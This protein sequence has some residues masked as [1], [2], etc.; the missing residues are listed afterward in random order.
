MPAIREYRSTCSSSSRLRRKNNSPPPLSF[1]A[2]PN[3]VDF[4]ARRHL[5]N[6]VYCFI[7]CIT[8]IDLRY[9]P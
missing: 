4:L 6:S 9:F 2:A 5:G 7:G 8:Y 3:C 1:R